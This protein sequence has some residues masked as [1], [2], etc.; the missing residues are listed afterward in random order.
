MRTSIYING[1]G[2]ISRLDNANDIQEVLVEPNYKELIPAGKIRRMSRVMRMSNYAALLAL[3]QANVTETESIN[4]A[5]GLGCLTDTEKFLSTLIDN[6]EEFANPSAFINSTHN[7]LAGNLA[8]LIGTKGQNFTFVHAENSF[9]YALLDASIA[10]EERV[11]NNFLVGGVDEK[12]DILEKVCSNK[13]IGEGASFVYVSNE[14]SDDNIVEVSGIKI[15]NSNMEDA[16]FIAMFLS[17]LGLEKSSL[18]LVLSNNNM[19]SIP[20]LLY[21]K[22]SGNYPTVS[23]FACALGAEI[24][25]TQ[26]VPAYASIAIKE[27]NKVLIFTKYLSGSKSLMLL[28]R[29]EKN[30]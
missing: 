8:I 16:S 17:E 27:V 3:R 22:I 25:H 15:D 10:L 1:I 20:T 11:C 18:D 4:L 13:E 14:K 12:T 2:S 26:K 19:L 28:K 5:T 21:N 24:I 23:A 29:V 30:M 9:E 7:T 6:N